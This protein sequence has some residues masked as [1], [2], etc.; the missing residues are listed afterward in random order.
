[1]Q[2]FWDYVLDRFGNPI[3]GVSVRVT[4]YP[5]D[6][7]AT[8]YAS[9]SLSTPTLNPTTTDN[10][11]FYQF[12]AANGRYTLYLDAPG[13]TT[14]VLRDFILEDIADATTLVISG[15]SINNTPIGATTPSTGEFTTLSATGQITSTLASGTAPFVV[16]STTL[17]PNLYVAKAQLSDSTTTNANLTGPITSVGNA[18]SVAS[19]TGTGSTFVMN[20]S[21]TLVTPNIGAA[22]GTSLSVTGQLASTVATGT[23]PLVVSSTTV[24]GNLNVSQLLGA[25]WTAPGAIG[26]VTPSSGAF[27]TLSASSTV[28]GAG[29]STYLASPPAIGGTAAAAGTFTALS[30][31]SETNSGNYT[32]TGTAARILGDFSN[33]TLANRV[34]FQTSTVNGATSLSV[35]PNGSGT[36]SYLEVFNGNAPV[37]ATKQSL[38]LGATSTDVRIIS[39]YGATPLPM[40]FYTG[41][42]E[43]MRVDTSGKVGIGRTPTGYKL[44]VQGGVYST[45]AGAGGNPAVVCRAHPSADIGEHGTISNHPMTF[46]TNATE[47]MRIDTSGNITQTTSAN[48]TISNTITNANVGAS[49]QGQLIV[50]SNAGSI[51]MQ[52]VSTA[53]GA[54]SAV[55]STGGTLNITTIDAQPLNFVTNSTTKFTIDSTGNAV[56]VNAAGG[57]G[58]GTGAGGTVTQ[59]TSKSTAVT[60]NKPTGQITMNNAALAA[61]TA[62][63]FVL[64]NS[65]LAATDILNLQANQS[66]A[67]VYTNYDIFVSPGAGNAVITVKNKSAGSLSDALVLNF[68]IIKGAT[69]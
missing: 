69:A 16:A 24:V 52:K 8:I 49:A 17:V 11:G 44:E 22:T 33:A 3:S 1:M 61:N 39:D 31:T 48:A 28:S 66:V 62:V 55:Y 59:A 57:L 13:M 2:K 64:N 29:F 19:Q 9:N 27:T 63:S 41:G 12:Y 46:I 15:G 25:T 54:Y 43:R 51:A 58:Y 23:A 67:S 30:A 47:R 21:P 35:V 40:T 65:L 5:S 4:N 56:V 60:L 37:A 14:Q 7:L 53:A 36:T 10:N 34:M 45:D 38:V 26:S 32:F 68:A 18:T 50:T 6:T 20:T 42:G